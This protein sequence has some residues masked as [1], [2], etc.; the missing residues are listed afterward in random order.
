MTNQAVFDA[1]YDAVIVGARCAGA[2]TALLL[3]EAGLRVLALDKSAPGKD[4][5]STHAL[6]RSA[7]LQLGRAGILD[8][9]RAAGTPPVRVTSF[10]Y[11]DE[12]IAIPIQP[13]DGIDA[14]YAP[15]RQLLDRLLVE[16]ARQS[17]AHV[18]HG[19]RVAE[20][21]RTPGGRVSGVVVTDAR[22]QARRVTSGIVIGADGLRSTVARQVA[23]PVERR[24]HHATATIYGYWAGLEADG[25]HWCYRPGV[26]SGVIPTN[27]GHACVFAT[28]PSSRFSRGDPAELH[29]AVVRETSPELARALGRGARVSALRSFPGERGVMRRAVGPGWALVGDAGLFR[30]PITAHGISDALVQAE[31]LARAVAR[32]SDQA[33]VRYQTERDEISLRLFEI[34]DAIAAFDWELATLR[35]LHI[36][37]S[38]AMKRHAS[39]LCGSQALPRPTAA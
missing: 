20:L 35:E 12:T 22:G 13:K 32:G 16:R 39:V 5:L 24:G 23:A 36:E 29:G 27:D 28:V 30:D 10:Q 11:A 25:Y 34:T 9:V 1:S 7:V 15:R 19:A 2:M 8:R 3:A 38:R 21:T 4:A 18:V 26:S 17:G 33:L 6:M 37:L 31:L 14:L